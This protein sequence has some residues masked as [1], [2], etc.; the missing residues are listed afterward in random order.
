MLRGRRG[1]DRILVA[2]GVMGNKCLP[3]RGVCA[4]VRNSCKRSSDWFPCFDRHLIPLG[5]RV[6]Q[7]KGPAVGDERFWGREV[8]EQAFVYGWALT[9]PPFFLYVCLP[10]PPATP[11]SWHL[12]PSPGCAAVSSWRGPHPSFDEPATADCS[13][14]GAENGE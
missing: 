5:R 12:L 11:P 1:T 14:E 4:S 9:L 10:S 7:G 2:G 8:L 3:I 6:E 13:Q